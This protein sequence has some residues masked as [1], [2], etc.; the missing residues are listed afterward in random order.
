MVEDIYN[1][2]RK[3]GG[4]NTKPLT[5]NEMK[6]YARVVSI[7]DGDTM[8]VIIPFLGSF[9][10]FAIRMYGIDSPEIKSKNPDI[11]DMA[12]KARNRVIE[13]VMK[14]PFDGQ[15]FKTKKDIETELENNVYLVWLHCLE[16][17]KY[18]RVLANVYASAAESDK[19]FADIL[20]AEKLAYPYFGKTKKTEGEQAIILG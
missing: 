10:K 3:H 8:H 5:L 15:R 14:A 19:S 1:I 16:M 2:F 11:K 9:F 20:I 12:L 18:G 17:D 13:L 7:Y 4:S 6:T